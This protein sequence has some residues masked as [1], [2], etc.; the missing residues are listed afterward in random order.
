[1][2][3]TKMLWSI[4]E[5]RNKILFSVMVLMLFRLGCA[6]P[7]PFINAD[8]LSG[9]FS[10]GNAFDYLNLMS[11]GALSQCAVLALGVTPYINASIIIQLMS[12]VIPSWGVARKDVEGQKKI[13]QYT[14]IL[15]LILA[16]FLSLGYMAILSR[17]GALEYTSGLSSVFAGAVIT[18]SFTAGSQFAFWLGKQIDD[19]GIG[20]GV[21]LLIFSGIV[22]RWYSI[23][24]IAQNTVTGIKE[25]HWTVILTLVFSVVILLASIWFVVYVSGSERRIPIQY[26]GRVAGRSRFRSNGSFLPLKLMMSGV[27][28]VIFASTV[29]SVPQTIALFLNAEKHPGI[30]KAL[31]SFNSTNLVWCLL[32]VVFIFFFNYFYVSIQ[33]D[34][35]EMANNLR[36][37]GGTIPGRRPGKPTSEYIAKAMSQIAGTGSVALTLIAIVPIFAQSVTGVYMPLSGTSLL[38]VVGVSTELV[39]ALD[40]YATVRNHKG[41]LA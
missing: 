3:K 37:N 38:I 13:E 19:H 5:L 4:P 29:L 25:G 34:A 14:K 30:V 20:N 36:K 15:S 1:M 21:S 11:G 9:L 31:L 35:V 17:Y 32:Y 26:A 39:A 12:V 40:S 23:I 2:S 6:I 7:V 24:S 16:V 41:F 28:P 10:T 33:Y 22:A 27:L 8:V 18:V